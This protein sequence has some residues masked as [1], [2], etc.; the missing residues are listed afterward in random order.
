MSQFSK[1]FK[2]GKTQLELDFVDIPLQTDVWLFIDPFA[3]SQRPDPWSQQA[4]RTIM[5]FFQRIVDYI[6]EGHLDGAEKLLSN[7]QEPNEIHFGLSKKESAGA[8]IG[9]YQAKQLFEALK[10]STAVTTGFLSSLEECELMIEGI[11]RDKISDL[12]ANVIRGHLAD[13]TKQECDLHGVPVHEVA[14]PP[15]FDADTCTWVSKYAWLPVWRHRP[16]LLVPKAI[17]RRAIAYDHQQYYRHYVLNYLQ[18]EALAAGS[19]LVRT[20]KSGKAVV[21]K[22]DLIKRFPCTKDFLYRFSKGHPDVLGH[23]RRTLEALEK[24]GANAPVDETDER[25]IASILSEALTMIP[26]GNAH[27][28]EYH[29]L[30]VGIIEFLFFPNLLN[31][32]KEKEIHEGRKRIDILVENGAR[33]GVLYRLH[34]VRHLPCAFVPIE[35]KNYTTE[36]ANPELDQL[37]GRF[38]VNRGRFGIMCC[39]KFEDRALFLERCQDTHQDN[40]GLIV[41]LDDLII[42]QLLGYVAAGKRTE[43]EKEF[44]HLIDEVWLG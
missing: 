10:G 4:H 22:K 19:S 11:G 38:S 43:I 31:P 9:P 13:Y 7:L 36:I 40:R 6:R 23:Y 14:M 44:A 37:A 42:L 16:I 39:R 30:I 8:G 41:A 3:I 28:G 21:Y 20:L 25:V 12:T 2:L 18:E 35:C 32:K 27:A 1:A 26:G 17:A 5:A 24:S 34:D 29:G 33:D 15:F